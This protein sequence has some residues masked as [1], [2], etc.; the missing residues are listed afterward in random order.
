MRLRSN[1]KP[2]NKETHL[3]GK[4]NFKTIFIIGIVLFISKCPIHSQSKIA[5]LIANQNYLHSQTL[6]TPIAE[7]DTLEKICISN[8]FKTLVFKDVSFNN[9]NSIL[10]SLEKV[11][12]YGTFLYI[13]YAGHGVQ[14]NG[15]N[16]IVPIDANPTTITQAERQCVQINQF[17]KLINDFQISHDIKSLVCIDACRNNPFK[18]ENINIGFNKIDFSPIN[19]GIIYSCAAGKK[20]LDGDKDY[21]PFA[22]IWIKQI[23]NC[24][25]SINDISIMI[26]GELLK[27]GFDEGHLPERRFVGLSSVYFCS[28]EKVNEIKSYQSKLLLLN[29]LKDNIDLDFFNR[30]YSSVIGKSRWID[31]LL[32]SNKEL[33]KNIPEADLLRIRYLESKSLYEISDYKNSIIGFESLWFSSISNHSKIP[34]EMLYDAYFYLGRLYS[35]QKKWSGLRKLRFQFLKFSRN[36]NHIL[37]VITTYDKIAGD[38]E[39]E[40]QIDSA[41]VYYNLSFKE[42][43]NFQITTTYEASCISS[44]YNNKGKFNLWQ[45]E[46]LLAIQSLDKAYYL[47]EKFDLTNHYIIYDLADYY[48]MYSNTFNKDSAILYLSKY[49]S[50]TNLITLQE[51]LNYLDLEINL[52]VRLKNQDSIKTKI[53]LYFN[54]MNKLLDIDIIKNEV[55]FKRFESLCEVPYMHISFI[56]QKNVYPIIF[57]DKNLNE[58]YDSVDFILTP[59]FL[60]KKNTSAI[61]VHSENK[62]ETELVMYQDNFQIPNSGVANL[63]SNILSDI[64]RLTPNFSMANSTAEFQ[65][66]GDLK[67]WDFKIYFSDIGIQSKIKYYIGGMNLSYDNIFLL[68]HSQNFTISPANQGANYISKNIK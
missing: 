67:K 34:D 31:S 64:Y 17:I 16:Y 57:I 62:K 14:L 53:D 50:A 41:K 42:C 29:N 24:N 9:Y 49:K 52:Y 19:T 40:N 54:E 7:I 20:A 8:D 68:R 39:G 56:V 45:R 32:N 3:I 11:I 1:G 44:F 58:E 60:D 36:N 30:N 59:N 28:N 10:D 27:L 21:S 13:H 38:C 15:E 48:T 63:Q 18:I 23:Q 2:I 5:V 55:E 22:K 35:L 4:V 12:D 26:D 46:P 6:R 66:I 37:D 43:E 61:V 25:L 65:E 51:R 33:K 47:Y